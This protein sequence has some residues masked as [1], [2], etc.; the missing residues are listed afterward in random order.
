[1]FQFTSGPD[2]RCSSTPWPLSSSTSCKGGTEGEQQRWKMMGYRGESSGQLTNY[3]TAFSFRLANCFPSEFRMRCSKQV[4]YGFAGSQF[5]L[6][7]RQTDSLSPPPSSDWI[8]L[9]VEIEFRS[10]YE[11]FYRVRFVY[12]RLHLQRKPWRGLS[13]GSCS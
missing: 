10:L 3:F 13:W 11:K 6:R 8:S 1:M 9:Q 2:T 5:Q 12:A 4:D 7:Y